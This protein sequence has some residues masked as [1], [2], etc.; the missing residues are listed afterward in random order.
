[1]PISPHTTSSSTLIRLTPPFDDSPLLMLAKLD[2]TTMSNE[3]L[4]AHIARLRELQSVQ[5]LKRA[6]GKPTRVPKA[7]APVKKD[8]L[9]NFLDDED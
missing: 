2:I 9:L 8:M 5:A 3:E 6:L 1:M 7:E 4:I